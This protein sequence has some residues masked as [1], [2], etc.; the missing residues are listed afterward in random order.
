[1]IHFRGGFFK[2]SF[3]YDLKIFRVKNTKQVFENGLLPESGDYIIT[4][5]FLQVDTL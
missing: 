4:G 2:L 5:D 3:T 1:M